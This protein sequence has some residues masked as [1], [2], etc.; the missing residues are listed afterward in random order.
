MF[1]AAAPYFQRRFRTSK[2]LLSNFQAAET[3]VATLANLASMLILTKLQRSANYPRRITTS[4][5]LNM[6]VFSLLAIS[7]KAFLGV[8]AAA[9]F[10]FAMAM[11]WAGSTATGFMQNGAFALAGGMGKPEYLQAIMT[12]QAVAGVLPPLVQIASVLSAGEEE[13]GGGGDGSST[14]AM[15]YFFTATGVSGVTLLAFIYLTAK[16]RRQTPKAARPMLAPADDEDD[17]DAADGDT[18]DDPSTTPPTR[19]NVPLSRLARRLTSIS[20]A[21]FLTFA[22]TMVFPVFTAQIHSVTPSTSPLLRPATFIPLAFLIWNTGDLFGRLIPLFPSL[23]L[24][25]RP[26]VLLLLSLLRLVFVPLYL[27]CNI[28]PTEATPEERAQKLATVRS[29]VFYLLVVQFPFGL[30]NGYLGSCCMMGAG[31][32]VEEGEKE[33]A[34]SFMGLML[35]SG[36][37]VGSFCSFLVGMAA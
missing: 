36:L 19:T 9:Y 3:S 31:D 37:A 33:A 15:A 30:S 5:L 26:R 21:V 24:A 29:D 35:V 4:L 22:V 27:L 2:P 7:T 16:H 13:E 6:L 1:L 32:L 17:A 8:S 14:S 34:G 20:A 10:T 18:T 11:V 23:S 12:G 28:V 25:T